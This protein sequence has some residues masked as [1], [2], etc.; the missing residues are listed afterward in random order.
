M[1]AVLGSLIAFLIE[2]DEEAIE[3]VTEECRAA[4]LAGD[5]SAVLGLIDPGASAG[6]LIG[7]GPLA[8]KFAEWSAESR[9]RVAGATLSLREIE[10]NG[11]D[12]RADWL[13]TVRM[14]EEEAIPFFRVRARIEYRRHPEG[15]RILHVEIRS[16]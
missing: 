11:E 5:E 9:R 13:V 8:R 7:K 16:P 10:V 6:G 2:T 15:W 1:A 12:A 14:K 4:F 3:R